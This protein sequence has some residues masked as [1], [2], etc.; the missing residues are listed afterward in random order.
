[1]LGV[2]RKK[3]LLYVAI[4]IFIFLLIV[5]KRKIPLYYVYLQTPEDYV[6][7]GQASWFDPW[8]INV[9]ISSITSGQQNGILLSNLY[10]TSN[11][12]PILIYP[13][14]TIVGYLFKQTSS[15]MLFHALSLMTMFMLCVAVFV[16][17]YAYIKKASYSLLAIP[18]VLL[19]RGL[20]GIIALSHSADVYITSFTFRSA[21]QR[22]HEAVGIILYIGAMTLFF[23]HSETKQKRFAALT[24]VFLLLLIVFYPYYLLVYILVFLLYALLTTKRFTY[25]VWV[26]FLKISFIVGIA[27]IAYFFYIYTSGFSTAASENLYKLP[28]ITV[29]CGYGFYLPLYVYSLIK[30]KE[31]PKEKLFL[32]L[33]VTICLILSYFPMGFARFYLRGL[34]FPL[35]LI[36]LFEFKKGVALSSKKLIINLILVGAILTSVITGMFV[37]SQKIEVVDKSNLWYYVPKEYFNGFRYLK[38]LPKGG[39]LAN[40]IISNYIPAYSGQKVYA[41]HLLQ[42]PFYADRERNIAIFYSLPISENENIAYL[43]NI[44]VSYVLY[45]SYEKMIGKRDPTYLKLL[46]SKNGLKIYQVI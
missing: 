19:G 8:D 10:S 25:P 12:N 22:P 21:L 33:W 46:Y 39:V 23:V 9:Y 27:T 3:L 29:I 14:Y 37:Y 2:S 4:F 24:L 32:I 16:F 28:L 30:F 20:G 45:G 18:L 38:Q 13:L 42:T 41:G 1:M 31:Q 44:H 5:L 26:E 11:D 15:F 36:I 40:P 17:T 7:S 34:F 43:K 6:F 35:A